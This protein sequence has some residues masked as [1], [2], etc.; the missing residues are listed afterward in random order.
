MKVVVG[1]VPV[2]L[3]LL[4]L[5]F[6]TMAHAEWPQF[7][8]PRGDGHSTATGL[9]L[10]W[11]ED[12]NVAWKV[13]LPGRGFS[14]PVILEG[15]VW[16]TTALDDE[17]SLRALAVDQASGEIVHD[18]ELFRPEAWQESHLENSYASPTP[19][20]EPGRVYFHFGSYG[21][22]A[23]ATAD[24]EVVWK[25]DALQLQ[26][27]VGPGSSPILWRDLLIVHC[28]GTDRRFVAA[29]DKETG[30]L[31][32]EAPRSIELERKGMH[33]KAFSTPL[34]IHHA[35][36]EQLVSPGAGQVSSY[37]PATG[38]EIWRVRYEGY[39]NVP[40]PVAGLGLVFVDTGY[41][42]P[43]MLAIHPGG[44]GDVTDTHVRWRYHW[45]VPANPSPLLI[46]GRL[47]MV[48]D[49]GIASWLDAR[50]GEDL[51]RQRLHG[52]YYASPIHAAGRIYNFS[53]EGRSVVVEASDDYRE[54]AVNQ[55]DGRIRASPAVADS[56]FFVRTET[57]L[58]RIE[59]QGEE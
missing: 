51:W 34:V 36:R 58:Y 2:L 50:K 30:E 49:W 10:T 26:H 3:S 48:S 40:R 32:W 42:K 13:A 28:D 33:Q 41:I 57:H 18:V 9:P 53:L 22:A 35:G 14:S 56:A 4:Y 39:S 43:H 21:T 7:R 20:I 59:K 25:S 16:M 15:K 47:Y 44:K 1:I 55:L 5:L 29:L 27:E 31:A 37:D 45:Q 38:E 24:A 11:S 52:R 6:P 54:L 23:L 17:R 8:G 19:V 46:G 12:D